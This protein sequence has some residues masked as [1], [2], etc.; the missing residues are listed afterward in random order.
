MKPAL[1]KIVT[2][3]FETFYGKDFSLSKPKYN[4]SSY[5]RDTQF[6]VHCCAVKIGKRKSVCYPASKLKDVFAKIDWATHSLLAHNTSFDGLIMKAHYGVVP[7]FYYDTLSMTRGLHN[8]VSRASLDTIAKLYQLGA[9]QQ[10]ALENTK[11]K[12]ELTKEELKRLLEYCNNDNELCWQVFMKQVEIYPSDELELIDLTIRMFA[13]SVLEVDLPVARQALGEEMMERRAAILKSGATEEELQSSQKFAE[14]LKALG[15]EP[16]M[17]ISPKTAYPSY[18]FAQTDQGF[19]DL[20]DHE[21]KKVVRLA[22]GRLAA[23]STQA[24]TRA[25]RLIQA[26]ESGTLP[27]GYNYFGAKTGRWSGTNKLNLQNLPRI[28]KYE[29]K[30]SDGLRH[31]IIAPEKHVLSVVD[32][33]QIEARVNAWLNG[34]RDVLDLFASGADVYSHMAATIYGKLVGKIT[35]SERFLGKVAVL[36]L[37]FGMGYL[38]FQTTLALGMMG[39]AVE[40]SATECKRIVNLYRGTNIGIAQ[41]WKKAQAILE[42]MARGE[43]GKCFDDLLEYEGTTL[44][45]PNGMG[46]HYP[47]LTQMENGDLKYSAHGVPKKIYGGL[48]IENIVQALARII[49]AD[50]MLAIHRANKKIGLKK[51]EVARVSMMTHDEVVNCV[52]ERVADKVLG[53]MLSAMRT[54]PA[55]AAGLPL[56]AEGG[57]ERRYSK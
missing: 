29:P 57:Y 7:S 10:G 56:D 51:G 54:A 39:P 11:D 9:K 45:L 3:D 44:W 47:G 33:A 26:G 30:P 2:V 16:P 34:Q 21:N 52:P 24:E 50:Q 18:A 40:L 38:K 49:V 8:E 1:S 5:V 42:R 36:G 35:K 37:G 12:R 55:W 32:S 25:A 22:Q 14:K 13:D 19:L 6:L 20:Q 46:L 31:S 28:N 17:K 15:V 53:T 23:K 27:V 48:F 4:T 43:S 41:G